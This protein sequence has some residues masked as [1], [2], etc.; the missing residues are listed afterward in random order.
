MSTA[1]FGP[2]VRAVCGGINCEAQGPLAFTRAGA[3]KLAGRKGFQLIE[4]CLLCPGHASVLRTT[5]KKR[6]QLALAAGEARGQK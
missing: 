5:I 6:M 1:R 3:V 4:G 2:F